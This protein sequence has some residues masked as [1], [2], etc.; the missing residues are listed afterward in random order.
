MAHVRSEMMKRIIIAILVT[1]TAVASADI[2]M[3]WITQVD[4]NTRF[5]MQG[6]S[7]THDGICSNLTRVA[8]F[9]TNMSI[10]VAADSNVTAAVVVDL[11]AV[12][13]S[14]GMRKVNLIV[15]GEKDGEKGLH[16]FPITLD[17]RPLYF[18]LG[19]ETETND[20]RSYK[21]MKMERRML[22]ETE[23]PDRAVTQESAPST[24]P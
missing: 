2:L 8:T 13:K 3:I 1:L 14:T 7:V 16:Q 18:G 6:R 11:L 23:Q 9:T 19:A 5:T 12:I 21:Q 4:G 20:F 10:F 22:G 17:Q 24:A 15:H